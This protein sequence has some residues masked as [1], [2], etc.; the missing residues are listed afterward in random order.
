MLCE[1]RINKTECHRLACFGNLTCDPF[2]CDCNAINCDEVYLQLRA[3]PREYIYHLI[4]WPLL[5]IMVTLL[6]V[7]FSIFAMRV[8]KS[9][10]TRGTYSPSRHEQQ[11]SRIEFNMDLKRP[12]EERLI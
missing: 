4:L 8:K 12:P 9:R 3:K 7:L 1:N 10:A 5:G 6:V 2:T 11:A